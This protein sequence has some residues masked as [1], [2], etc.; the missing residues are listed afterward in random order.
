MVI[1][2]GKVSLQCDSSPM[3]GTVE[4]VGEDSSKSVTTITAD[5][6][7]QSP[8]Y[9]RYK[10]HAI[11]KNISEP[12]AVAVVRET[13][14]WVKEQNEELLLIEHDRAI[15][16]QGKGVNGIVI[17]KNCILEAYALPLQNNSEW[18]LSSRETTSKVELAFRPSERKTQRAKKLQRR[19]L[20]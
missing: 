17:L 18:V 11:F 14:G 19:K 15:P 10:D 12:S 5:T 3:F 16:S 4:K 9:I 7:S 1:G 20:D 8:I 2:A 6:N 13:I